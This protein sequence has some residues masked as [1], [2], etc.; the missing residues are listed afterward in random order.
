MSFRTGRRMLDDSAY[1]YPVAPPY[2]QEYE[3]VPLEPFVQQFPQ[4]VALAKQKGYMDGLQGKEFDTPVSYTDDEMDAYED[5]YDQGD[6]RREEMESEEDYGD[7][8]YDTEE[9]V[10]EDAI[11][12]DYE[13]EDYGDELF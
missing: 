5:G 7:K 13:R 10:E 1:R 4:E 6:I 2:R 11:Y 9:S 8:S 3:G 12:G